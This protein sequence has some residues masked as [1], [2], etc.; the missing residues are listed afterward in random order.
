M[1]NFVASRRSAM[2]GGLGL[3]AAAVGISSTRAAQTASNIG[4]INAIPELARN[5]GN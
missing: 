1:A 5:G 4:G 2:L 3:A